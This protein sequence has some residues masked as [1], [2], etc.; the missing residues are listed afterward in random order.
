M[1]LESADPPPWPL[2]RRLGWIRRDHGSGDEKMFAW[3]AK[4][5]QQIWHVR[6][7]STC[8]QEPD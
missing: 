8:Q 4:V 7:N 5:R 1:W 6:H 2:W 3:L